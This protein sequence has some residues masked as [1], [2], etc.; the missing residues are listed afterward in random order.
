MPKKES[1][2]TKFQ[3]YPIQTIISR[4]FDPPIVI[5]LLT[6]YAVLQSTISKQ[7]IMVFTLCIPFLFGIPLAFLV[8]KLK[9]HKVSNWDISNRKERIV[10]L[11][12]LLGFLL[13]DIIIVAIFHNVF[14]LNLF[15]LYFLWVFG[16]FVITLVWKISG[17][18]GITTLAAMLLYKWMGPQAWYVFLAI[19]L[20]AWARISRKDHTWL[21]AVAGIMYSVIIVE[22]WSYFFP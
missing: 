7:G 21:Q 14:L 19:P 13:L 17:H 8:W 18:T 6:V 15:I 11:M 5:M 9:T 12:A 1:L 16:F 2:Q 20:V 3:A 10:P 22:V 4:V